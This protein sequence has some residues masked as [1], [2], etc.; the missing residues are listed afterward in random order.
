MPRIPKEPILT[1][2]EPRIRV[3]KFGL[4]HITDTPDDRDFVASALLGAPRNVR[5]E[6]S[7][8]EFVRRVRDQ[9]ATSSCV[10][11][12][13]ASAVDI[14][15]RKMGFDAPEPNP[16]V[17]YKLARILARSSDKE[18]L[19]DAGSMARYAFKGLRDVGVVSEE[20]L[21][22][23]PATV[24]DELPWDI[25]QQASVFRVQAWWRIKQSGLSRPEMMA[26]ALDQGYPVPF[27]MR[28]DDAFMGYS[29]RISTGALAK[30]FEVAIAPFDRTKE[31]GGHMICAVAYT[32]LGNGKKRFMVLNSWSQDWGWWGY[33]FVDEDDLA[34]DTVSDAHVVQVGSA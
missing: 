8:E 27:A 22:F 10:G 30:K 28:V 2:D 5:G 19:V 21:P 33:F 34:V 13:I 9:S 24:N 12:G 23:D 25:Y 32:T 29:P 4:G 11:H 18:S 26:H 6:A 7:L 16:M 3:P 1:S 17:V 20:L 15:L 14:R 31:V